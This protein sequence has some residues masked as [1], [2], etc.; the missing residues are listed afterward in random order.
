MTERELDLVVGRLLQVGVLLA[1]VVVCVGVPYFLATH[2]GA[3]ADFRVFRPQPDRL[4]HVGS[5]LAGVRRLDA[6]SIVQ[7]GVLLLV[8]T[9]VA[10]VLFTFLAFLV[11]R[12]RPFVLLSGIVLALLLFGLISGR[13]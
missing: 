3:V 7:L 2:A 6:E 10:R 11:Q 12:D 5:I 13:A 9:P 8:L 1:A 4:R